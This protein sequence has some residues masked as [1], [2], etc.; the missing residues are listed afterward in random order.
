MNRDLIK[1]YLVAF[2]EAVEPDYRDKIK[3][4]WYCNGFSLYADNMSL[5]TPIEVTE[6]QLEKSLTQ[7]AID[8][9]YY[10]V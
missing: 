5:H 10:G 9:N 8:V 4:E 6:T 3:I 7:L 2:Y 1:Q